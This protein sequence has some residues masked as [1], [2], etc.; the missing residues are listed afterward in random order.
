[1]LASRNADAAS[2]HEIIFLEQEKCSTG[3]VFFFFLKYFPVVGSVCQFELCARFW[4]IG[5]IRTSHAK[6]TIHKFQSRGS[7][8]QR[9]TALAVIQK[10][11]VN[12]HLPHKA[13]NLWLILLVRNFPLR[14][15]T[16]VLFSFASVELR[17]KLSVSCHGTIFFSH[18]W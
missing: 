14:N 8:R 1:M 7:E 17:L 9:E 13:F 18:S 11:N 5:L 4:E 12:M 6:F 10:L 16:R 2:P 3:I 15:A